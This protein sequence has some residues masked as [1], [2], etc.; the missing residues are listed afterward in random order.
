MRITATTAGWDLV[1]ERGGTLAFVFALAKTH[2]DRQRE[3]QF[4]DLHAIRRVNGGQIV[5]V[6]GKLCLCYHKGRRASGGF[7][8]EFVENVP[9]DGHLLFLPPTSLRVSQ[10]R[11]QSC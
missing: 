10:L 9:L 5:I 6:V 7:L 11:A 1:A 3:K 2:T 8:I 4:I